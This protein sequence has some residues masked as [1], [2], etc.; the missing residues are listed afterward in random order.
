MSHCIRCNRHY[1]EPPDE[2][3]EHDCPHCGLQPEDRAAW[4]RGDDDWEEIR[5]G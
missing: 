1:N 5:N 2:Q 3:G 4:L